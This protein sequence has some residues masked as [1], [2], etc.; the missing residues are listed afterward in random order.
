[1]LLLVLSALFFSGAS[2]YCWCKASYCACQRAGQCDNPISFYWLAG[3]CASMIALLLCCLALHTNTGTALWLI[4]TL[5]CLTGATLSAKL[6]GQKQ[7]K[8][9]KLKGDLLVGE[10]N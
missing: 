4:L 8:R 5:S 7:R 1:M 6:S 9:I 2:V 3:I 10:I